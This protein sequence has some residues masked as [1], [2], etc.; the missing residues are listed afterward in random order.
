MDVDIATVSV[1]CEFTADTRVWTL[2]IGAEELSLRQP[3][4][5]MRALDVAE[6][7]LAA[8]YGIDVFEWHMGDRYT[9]ASWRPVKPGGRPTNIDAAALLDSVRGG[10]P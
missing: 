9:P 8:R 1:T 2:R 4:D 3:Y 7:Y 5:A 10:Q 6:A